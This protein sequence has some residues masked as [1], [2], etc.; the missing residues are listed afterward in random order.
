M[1]VSISQTALGYEPAASSQQ[2]AEDPESEGE[3]VFLP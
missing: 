1:L 3:C 2:P